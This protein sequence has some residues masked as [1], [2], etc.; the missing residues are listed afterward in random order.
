MHW[1][2]LSLTTLSVG[3]IVAAVPSN[4]SYPNRKVIEESPVLDHGLKRRADQA[5]GQLDGYT[6]FYFPDDSCTLQQKNA[7]NYGT[8][9]IWQMANAGF[10]AIVGLRNSKGQLTRKP[11]DVYYPF[12]QSYTSDEEHVAEVMNAVMM[13]SRIDYALP[14]PT[15]EQQTPIV[16]VPDPQAARCRPTTQGNPWGYTLKNFKQEEDAAQ[17]KRAI[18]L[19]PPA[20]EAS[21]LAREL[22]EKCSEGADDNGLTPTITNVVFKFMVYLVCGEGQIKE[23]AQGAVA[24]QGLVRPASPDVAFK[25]DFDIPL[26]NADSYVYYAYLAWKANWGL[27]LNNMGAIL[28]CLRDIFP[29]GNNNPNVQDGVIET[30]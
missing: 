5:P 9:Y 15:P 23:S 8:D 16:C 29:N 7:I 2:C 3:T 19:C 24:S 22:N 26:K 6:R 17:F 4:K 25:G 13:D 11:G 18:Y 10:Q 27:G 1:L 30:A 20:L 28:R 21:F 12:F 14:A